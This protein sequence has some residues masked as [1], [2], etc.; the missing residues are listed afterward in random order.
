MGGWF[1]LDSGVGPYIMFLS[2][3]LSAKIMGQVSVATDTN[4]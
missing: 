4:R 1:I 3:C 2:M